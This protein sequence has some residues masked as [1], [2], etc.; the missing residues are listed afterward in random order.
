[1][2]SGS[3]VD[4]VPR[5]SS[6]SSHSGTQSQQISVNQANRGIFRGAQPHSAF[7]YGIQHG[8]NIRWRTSDHLKNIA[9]RRLL[10]Q[11]FSESLEQPNVLDSDHRLIGKGFEKRDLLLRERTNFR[12][13][14]ENSAYRYAFSEQRRN[15]YGS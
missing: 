10:L 13:A 5:P 3:A 6:E 2:N 14:Y 1:M 8:L 15:E 9:R 7:R 4:L 12:S 11:C